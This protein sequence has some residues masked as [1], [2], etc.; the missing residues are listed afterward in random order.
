MRRTPGGYDAKITY[1]LCRNEIV[2]V[3]ADAIG[4]YRDTK[5]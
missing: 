2:L 3:P 5:Q 1:D 4:H